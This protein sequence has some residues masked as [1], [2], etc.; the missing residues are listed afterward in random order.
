MSRLGNMTIISKRLNS[1]ARNGSFEDKRGIYGESELFLT[2]ELASSEK[3]LQWDVD[4]VIR[5]Q[6]ELAESAVV[7]WR[8]PEV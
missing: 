2:R 5:R 6:K 3:Y 7:I 1:A 4:A 8:F